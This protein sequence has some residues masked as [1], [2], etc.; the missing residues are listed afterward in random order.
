M[1]DSTDRDEFAALDFSS[2]NSEEFGA[3]GEPQFDGLD[4]SASDASD[5]DSAID[6]LNEYA[7]AQPQVAGAELEALT[8]DT[9]QPDEEDVLEPFTFTVTNPPGIVSVSALIGGRIR[10]VELSPKVTS[11]SEAEL[12][13][14]ILV[15]A[16]LARQKALAGQQTYL[17]DNEL[18]SDGMRELGLES[19]EV[20]RDFMQNGLGMPSP[21][22]AEAE[23]AE[24]FAT[25]YSNDRG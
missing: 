24:V 2:D 6:A 20:V 21:E 23:Q 8:E 22:Q 13:E 3:D 16:G 5:E 1:V 9:D 25:R 15:L 12:A 18:L 14:E 19:R 11:M 4:F 7:P 17:M 10:E